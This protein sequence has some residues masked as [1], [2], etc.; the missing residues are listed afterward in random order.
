MST[1]QISTPF[2]L[3]LDFEIAEFHRR[4]LA[5]CIDLFIMVL[6]AWIMGNF[7]YADPV[8]EIAGS[9]RAGAG[10]GILLISLP[11]L[12]YPLICEIAMHGQTVGKKILDIRVMNLHGGE[13][14]LSQYM[15]RWIF[16]FFEWPLVFGVAVPGFYILYRLAGM[17]VP[18]LVVIIIMAVT[19]KH[20][21]L[22]DLAANTV[23]VK[24]RINTS[25]NDTIFQEV[26][27]H[28]YQV[29]FPQVMQLSDRDINT[30]KSVI[31]N[32]HNKNGMQLAQRTA[33]RVKSALK[34]DTDTETV[35][36]LEKLLQ[37][38][39]YLATKE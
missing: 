18:G 24:T 15:L 17:I 23:L 39:N 34:I 10:W 35:I 21:R 13:P 31:N 1:V 30:I 26:D 29:M 25:I 19:N 5:Y 14:V 36:F 11:I 8:Q 3:H 6:Y 2:N 27:Q 32:S 12:L 33:D 20:Q 38:Y 7:V 22:G 16:R 9:S 4:V 37:D 28:N